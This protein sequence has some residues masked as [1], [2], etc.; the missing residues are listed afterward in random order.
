ML[1]LKKWSY[2]ITIFFLKKEYGPRCKTL[3]LT[4]FKN[5]TDNTEGRCPTCKTYET[6]DFLT[7]EINIINY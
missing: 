7:Q 2:K 6:I 1:I 4:D 3:D 5:I